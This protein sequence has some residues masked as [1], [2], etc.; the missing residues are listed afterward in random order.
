MTRVAHLDFESR[1]RINL[2]L[3]GPDRY[4]IDPSFEILMASVSRD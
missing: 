4:A 2:K 1:S 3:T